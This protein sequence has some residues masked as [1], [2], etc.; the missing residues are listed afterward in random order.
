MFGGTNGREVHYEMNEEGE[1]L[2]ELDNLEN[3][4]GAM[5]KGSVLVRKDRIIAVGMRVDWKFEFKA[6]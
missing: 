5:N 6:V 2:K 4:P 3:I 1:D